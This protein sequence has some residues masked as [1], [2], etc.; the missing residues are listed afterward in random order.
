M[1]SLDYNTGNSTNL[2]IFFSPIFFRIRFALCLFQHSHKIQSLPVDHETVPIQL[3]GP[4]FRV[5]I[6]NLEQ[7]AAFDRLA[8]AACRPDVV[9]DDGRPALYNADQMT[10]HALLALS[11]WIPLAAELAKT[12]FHQFVQHG[13]NDSAIKPLS[14]E[15][16]FGPRMMKESME[17]G[18][19]IEPVCERPDQL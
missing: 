18:L 5:A 6:K 7:F 17:A 4:R 9:R 11:D 15:S 3:L 19:G 8:Q 1:T 14:R 12:L 13:G 16:R 10:A 2:C